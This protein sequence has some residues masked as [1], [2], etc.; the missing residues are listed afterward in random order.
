[1]YFLNFD[2]IGVYII[3]DYNKK[4]QNQRTSNHKVIRV[5]RDNRRSSNPDS[6]QAA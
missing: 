4:N 5:G 2:F 1:M 6:D 3:Q